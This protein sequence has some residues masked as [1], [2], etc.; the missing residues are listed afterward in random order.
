MRIYYLYQNLP[1]RLRELKHMAESYEKKS[2]PKPSKS[3]GTRWIEN[4]LTAMQAMFDNYGAY[5]T[6]SHKNM[7]NQVVFINV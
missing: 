3:Y 4:K 6:V 1:K 2:V 7:P 5:M